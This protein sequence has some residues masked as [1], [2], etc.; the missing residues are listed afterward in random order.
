[1][2]RLIALVILLAFAPGC[3]QACAFSCGGNMDLKD[4]PCGHKLVNVTWKSSNLWYLTRPLREDDILETYTFT[5]SSSIGV[6]EG[7]VTIKECR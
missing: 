5:E 2:C 7:T 1:M 6:M 4:F 3:D